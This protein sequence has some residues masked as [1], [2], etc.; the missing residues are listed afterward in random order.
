MTTLREDGQHDVAVFDHDGEQPVLAKGE[1]SLPASDDRP[2]CANGPW[3]VVVEVREHLITRLVTYNGQPW[4]PV[5][6]DLPPG[7]QHPG[8]VIWPTWPATVAEEIATSASPLADLQQRWDATISRLRD[9]AKWMAAVIGAALASVIPTAPLSGLSQH[10]ISAASAILGV[11]GLLFV[12]VTLLLILRVMR[13]QSVSYADVQEAKTPIGIQGKLRDRIRKRRPHSHA[14]ESPSYRWQHTIQ[15]HPDLYLP[16]GVY[17]LIALRQLMTVEEITLIAL[18][19]A[20][21]DARNDVA[22]KNLSDAQAARAARLYELRTAAAN[23]VTVGT[24]Y[25]TRARSTLATYGGVTFGL[26]GILAIVAS[27]AWPIS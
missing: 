23:V 14:L 7:G 16:C 20:G 9:S 27:I 17:S 8:E 22:R 5:K 2:S 12:S 21:V 3:H 1:Y 13:P 11:T 18:S 19:R 15:A 26:L 24:Y 10:H 25:D 6:D 4:S